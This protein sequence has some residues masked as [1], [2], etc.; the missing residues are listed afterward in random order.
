MFAGFHC[1][2]LGNKIRG[3]LLSTLINISEVPQVEDVG[4]YVNVDVEAHPAVL[5]GSTPQFISGSEKVV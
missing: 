1:V 4:V 2:D 5:M 3:I